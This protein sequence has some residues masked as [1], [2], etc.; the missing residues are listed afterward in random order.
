MTLN[1]NKIGKYFAGCLILWLMTVSVI[2]AFA[3]KSNRIV[4]AQSFNIQKGE[5][6]PDVKFSDLI[7]PKASVLGVFESNRDTIKSNNPYAKYEYSGQLYEQNPKF[8]QSLE[9]KIS[10]YIDT[11]RSNEGSNQ[12]FEVPVPS[13]VFLETSLKYQV[14]L[15]YTLTIARL[16]SRFGTDCY[17]ETSATRIC[18]HKN[19]YSL[20]LDD[21]GNNKTFQNWEDGVYAFGKWYQ[22]RINEGYST[23]QIWRRYNPNGD[24]CSKVL[25]MAVDIEKYFNQN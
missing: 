16:E 10:D 2:F 15:S 23:C 1:L 5:L 11:F 13:I 19:I 4:R 22:K 6:I 21:S 24:Y 20:G 9:Q 8:V 18:K 25:S 17:T 7:S 3:N 12:H 14:P